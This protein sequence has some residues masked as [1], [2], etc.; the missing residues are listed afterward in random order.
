VTDI[1]M[2]AC[3]PFEEAHNWEQNLRATVGPG[4]RETCCA[5]GLI[6]VR[7]VEH[8]EGE[9]VETVEYDTSKYEPGGEVEA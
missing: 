9:E 6:R 5:C 4:R 3:H 2:P 7:T 8:R 1:E